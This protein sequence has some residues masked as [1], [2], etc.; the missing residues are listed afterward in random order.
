M[1]SEARMTET[2]AQGLNEAVAPA[3]INGNGSDGS[4]PVRTPRPSARAR[5]EMS[6]PRH[7]DDRADLDTDSMPMALWQD[8][9]DRLL[10]VH[11]A[12][13]FGLIALAREQLTYIVDAARDCLETGHALAGEADPARHA[14]LLVSHARLRLDRA[15]EASA[16][17]LDLASRPAREIMDVIVDPT[18]G[19]SRAG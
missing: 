7:S 10:R 17:V 12:V 18:T 11:E 1:K 2:V 6:L 9:L 4:G 8:G 5:A 14:D 16:R 15:I 19:R 3:F 13:A